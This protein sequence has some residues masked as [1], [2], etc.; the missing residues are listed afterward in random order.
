MKSGATRLIKEILSEKS[1]QFVGFPF[2]TDYSK[3]ERRA[4]VEDALEVIEQKATRFI[5]GSA[6]YVSSGKSSFYV[7]YLVQTNITPHTKYGVTWVRSEAFDS[8][9]KAMDFYARHALEATQA[10]RVWGERSLA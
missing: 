7:N 2:N 6:R 5:K 9:A 4:D 8:L 10:Y 3:M 1:F